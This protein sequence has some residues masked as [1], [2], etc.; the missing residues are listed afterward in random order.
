V[1]EPEK[2]FIN[3][4]VDLL[5][6][7]CVK[8]RNG[9]LFRGDGKNFN[10]YKKN[11]NTIKANIIRC[12]RGTLIR[13]S[14]N[15]IRDILPDGIVSQIVKKKEFIDL[16]AMEITI[17]ESEALL[18]SSWLVLLIHGKDVERPRDLLVWQSSDYAWSRDALRADGRKVR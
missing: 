6:D 13:I 15:V 5:G 16:N 14:V 18:V 12:G 17:T 10:G 2:Q 3:A 11:V 9:V 7:D 4:I 1:S 8:Y